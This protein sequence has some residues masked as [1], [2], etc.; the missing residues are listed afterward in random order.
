MPREA[1]RTLPPD[2]DAMYRQAAAGLAGG[3]LVCVGAC[4]REAL[5]PLDDAA[6][7]LRA[8]WPTC[9]GKTMAVA[10]ARGGVEC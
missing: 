8:G 9:C 10:T 2:V 1:A 7:Y 4:R 3:K 6:R 5:L